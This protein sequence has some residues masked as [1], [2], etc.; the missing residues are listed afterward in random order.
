MH[1][2]LEKQSVNQKTLL[3][4]YLAKTFIVIPWGLSVGGRCSFWE[5]KDPSKKG[6]GWREVV[7]IENKGS[8]ELTAKKSRNELLNCYFQ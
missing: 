6:M 8:A 4:W 1:E 2:E 5:G 3:F 7:G